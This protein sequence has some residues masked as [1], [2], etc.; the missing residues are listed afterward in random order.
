MF[1]MLHRAC[2]PKLTVFSPVCFVSHGPI[3]QNAH[4]MIHRHVWRKGWICPRL[5]HPGFYSIWLIQTTNLG[6]WSLHSWERTQ[7]VVRVLLDSLHIKMWKYRTD[8]LTAHPQETN[9]EWESVMW[10]VLWCT[11]VLVS[12]SVK[13]AFPLALSDPCVNNTRRV[14]WSR[15]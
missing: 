12:G 14:K 2:L 5:Y 6:C 1:D 9:L 10:P 11:L 3:C 15:I 7:S 8:Q 13:Q 4:G